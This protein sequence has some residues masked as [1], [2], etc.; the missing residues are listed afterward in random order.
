MVERK[1]LR[2]LP[3]VVSGNL[4]ATAPGQS[5]MKCIKATYSTQ[6]GDPAGILNAAGIASL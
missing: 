4:A 6:G 2:S 1:M 3:N 5:I